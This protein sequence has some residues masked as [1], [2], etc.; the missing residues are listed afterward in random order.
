MRRCTYRFGRDPEMFAERAGECLVRAVVRVQRQLQDIGRTVDKRARR[1]AE[2]AGKHIAHHRQPGRGGERPDHVEARDSSDPSDLVE[3]Q[4]ASEMA[5]NKPERLLGRI[6]GYS[7]V[8][9][10]S[11]MIVSRGSHLTVLARLCACLALRPCKA[12][13][14]RPCAFRCA[15]HNVQACAGN[16]T[17]IVHT[18]RCIQ[19]G[20]S[21]LPAKR[22][23]LSLASTSGRTKDA[24]PRLEAR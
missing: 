23:C 11:I 16:V 8:R 12:G 21:N 24:P 20:L 10:A 18:D 19:S 22:L 15:E 6:H 4:V 3:A 9:S 2:A 1:L 13:T 5:L 14:K 17:P 7:L